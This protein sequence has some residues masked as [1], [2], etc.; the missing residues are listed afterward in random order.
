MS[1]NKPSQPPLLQDL[2]RRL[3]RALAGTPGARLHAT[4]AARAIGDETLLRQALNVIDG[5]IEIGAQRGVM[6]TDITLTIRDS[7]RRRLAG[8]A[9]VPVPPGECLAPNCDCEPGMCFQT[10]PVTFYPAGGP[11][12]G[13]R[14]TV[15]G[16]YAWVPEHGYPALVQ[17]HR[18]PTAHAPGN[19]LNASVL[20]CSTFYDGCALESWPADGWVLLR[21]TRGVQGTRE[22]SGEKP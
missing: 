19:Q 17:V 3:S 1:D 8:G 11:L 16:L 6:A 9:G 13:Q 18:R 15:P 5:I 4:E 2:D 20:P 12:E 10:M 21:P 14:P 22:L 7:L